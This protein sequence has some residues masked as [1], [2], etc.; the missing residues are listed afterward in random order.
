MSLSNEIYYLFKSTDI[1]DIESIND[2]A[3][4]KSEVDEINLENIS[5]Y[6]SLT[7]HDFKL[8]NT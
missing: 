5:D 2:R 4:W 6:I 8:I 7:T 1:I 3:K